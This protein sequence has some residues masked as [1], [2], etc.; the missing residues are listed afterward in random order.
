[1]LPLFGGG[2][3]SVYVY[4]K[5]SF[6]AL[7]NYIGDRG[8]TI[9]HTRITQ[10]YKFNVYFMGEKAECIDF[11]LEIVDTQKPYPFY[12][13]VK[14]T[15]RGY[16]KKD[17]RINAKIASGKLK[18]LAKRPIP[19]Y[20]AAVDVPQ[21]KVYICPAF[22]GTEEY[23]SSMPVTHILEKGNPNSQAT[24]DWLVKDV[25]RFWEKNNAIAIKKSFISLL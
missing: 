25:I 1:M 9:F 13:Q 17:G 2:K 21:E 19:T 11:M 15:E 6:M 16:T 14:S 7:Q 12:V 18:A 10:G 20:V 3:M 4:R 5:D 24:L 22:Q 23:T 8:E